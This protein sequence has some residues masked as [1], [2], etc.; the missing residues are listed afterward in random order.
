MLVR[1]SRLRSVYT[2]TA[3]TSA[4][5]QRGKR[6][7]KLKPSSIHRELNRPREGSGVIA[8]RDPFTVTTAR[9]PYGARNGYAV[10]AD[11]QR[12]NPA[13][14]QHLRGSNRQLSTMDISITCLVCGRHPGAS[15][16]RFAACGSLPDGCGQLPVRPGN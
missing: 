14:T 11:R 6:L 16:N 9:V 5:Q 15:L 1:A 10:S 3:R 2:S 13:T 12:G 4:M 8:Q 7:R